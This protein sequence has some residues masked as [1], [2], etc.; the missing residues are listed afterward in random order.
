MALA[1]SE[2]VL[3]MP[4][5]SSKSAWIRI[6]ECIDK[7]LGFY[8]LALLIVESFLAIVLTRSALDPAHQFYGVLIGVGMFAVVVGIVSLFAW[9]GPEDLTL[10]KE[11][12]LK[13]PRAPLGNDSK[14]VPSNVKL[15][16]NTPDASQNA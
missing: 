14:V 15:V 6:I 13:R 7:P 12:D 5:R 8:V 10:D 3:K 11:A 4:G 16:P 2:E 1:K 9:L